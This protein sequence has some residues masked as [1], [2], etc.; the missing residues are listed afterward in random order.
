MI[1]T[2]EWSRPD[3]PLLEDMIKVNNECYESALKEAYSA[4]ANDLFDDLMVEIKD[5][6]LQVYS[7]ASFDDYAV[8][9]LE[10]LSGEDMVPLKDW[11]NETQ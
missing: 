1:D 11:T 3:A 5:G 10:K 8:V 2:S 7:S 4:G 9:P 6:K